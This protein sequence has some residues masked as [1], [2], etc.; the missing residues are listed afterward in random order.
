[1]MAGAAC[2]LALALA[3]VAVL[4][5]LCSRR[6]PLS[7]GLQAGPL[8]AA[9]EPHH[10]DGGERGSLLLVEPLAS[11]WWQQRARGGRRETWEQ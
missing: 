4:T 5:Q 6:L 11:C 2:Q 9:C 7:A 3:A 10:H 1:M 8:A